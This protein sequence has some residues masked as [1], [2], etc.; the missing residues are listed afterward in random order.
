[1]FAGK[2]GNQLADLHVHNELMKM[3]VQKN[4]GTIGKCPANLRPVEKFGFPTITC[5][6]YIPQENEWQE[7]WVTFFASQ[8]LHPQIRLIERDYGDRTL[9]ELWSELQMKVQNAFRD[10]VI[11]PSLLHGDL[12]EANVAEDDHGPVLFDP[13]SFYGH[14]EYDLSIGDMFGDHCAD[15]YEAY[16]RKIPKSPG[17]ELRHPLYKLFHSLNNW[18]HFGSVFRKSTLDLMTY[19]LQIL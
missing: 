17:F 11:V 18:N 4:I 14:S 13:A 19:L 15:F 8:R 5:C 16:H 9:L 1:M 3:K 2:L 12:W 7:D 10:T 6:G